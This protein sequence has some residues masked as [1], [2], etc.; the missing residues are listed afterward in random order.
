MGTGIPRSILVYDL[1]TI[2]IEILF[3]NLTIA[4]DLNFNAK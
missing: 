2:E 1:L 4:L 3:L